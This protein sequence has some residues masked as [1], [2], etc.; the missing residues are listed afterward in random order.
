MSRRKQ[1]EFDRD[2]F[3]ALSQLAADRMA[4]F[5]DLADEAFG[6]LLRKHRRPVGLKAALKQSTAQGGSG[7]NVMSLRPGR[8]KRV[9]ADKKTQRKRG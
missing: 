5:Q 4:T 8:R 9:A 2:T 6:D 7:E 1:I 3:V